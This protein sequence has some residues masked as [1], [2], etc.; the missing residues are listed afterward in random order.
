[1]FATHRA[2]GGEWFD[3]EYLATHSKLLL[4]ALPGDF[5]SSQRGRACPP[6]VSPFTPQGAVASPSPWGQPL[7]SSVSQTPGEIFCVYF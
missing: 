3:A 5:G 1:M 6:G 4:L 2:W 7:L